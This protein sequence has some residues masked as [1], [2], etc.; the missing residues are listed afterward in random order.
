MDWIKSPELQGVAALMAVLEFAFLIWG[1]FRSSGSGNQIV[2]TPALSGPGSPGPKSPSANIPL[3][4]AGIVFLLACGWL[5]Y[6][7]PWAVIAFALNFSPAATIFNFIFLIL[8]SLPPLGALMTKSMS[9]GGFLGGG[10]PLGL[11]ALFWSSANPAM[12]AVASPFAYFLVMVVIGGLLGT[13]TGPA[14]IRLARILKL[15]VPFQ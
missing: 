6:S 13:I 8:G 10:I 15:P 9:V 7:L 14:T 3:R 2:Q 5:T 11:L 1:N 4:V 12:Q